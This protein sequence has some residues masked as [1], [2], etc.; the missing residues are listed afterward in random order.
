MDS[1]Q[2]L[3]QV[4]RNHYQTCQG[5]PTP[6]RALKEYYGK[7]FKFD[8]LGLGKFSIWMEHNKHLFQSETMISEL[9]DDIDKE[10]ITEETL[11]ITIMLYFEKSEMF[12]HR[13]RV[14]DHLRTIYGRGE[15]SDFGYGTFRQFQKKHNLDMGIARQQ[16]FRNISEWNKWK[17]RRE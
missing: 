16:D 7:G 11:L 8:N 6:L 3:I 5:K 4:L 10:T 14:L 9:L 15:F 2:E 17:G 13:R 1:E 12:Y